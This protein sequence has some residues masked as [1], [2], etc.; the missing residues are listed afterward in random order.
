MKPGLEPG[1]REQLEMEV[2]VEMC[3]Q[4]DGETVHQTM[5][6]VSM[7]YHMEWVARKV[8]LP[9]LEDGEEGIG[10]ELNV[11]HSAPAPVGKKVTF[12]AEV[13]HNDGSLV[14]CDVRAVH[15]KAVVGAGSF[16][17]AILPR[18]KIV[19]RIEAMS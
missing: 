17:Q 5:S 16:T 9:F 12:I 1:Y 8:I 15:D 7:I 18:Q 19:D 2:T 11:R 13:T 10:A 6:T 4:F 3:P 14:I